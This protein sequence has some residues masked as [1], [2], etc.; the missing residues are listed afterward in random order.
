VQGNIA[1]IKE[2]KQ[3]ITEIIAQFGQ[4]D[5]LVNA[6]G[7]YF[8]KAL[9]D[10]TEEAYEQIMDVNVKGTYFMCQQVIEYLQKS[11]AGAIVNVSSDAGLNGNF[12]CSAYCASKGAVTV[13]SKA[14][15]LELAPYH[16]RVNCVCPGDIDTPLTR[17]QFRNPMDPAEELREMTSVYPIGRIG[18]AEEV[19]EVICFL[20]SSKA[21]FVVG[22]AWSVDGGVTAY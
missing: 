21:S 11:P 6:A 7:I 18:K 2:C 16:I 5:V 12:L 1:H 3:M 13:F 19:A 15:A 20:A 8:E 14:L 22:A 17:A 10:M 9:L 4:I